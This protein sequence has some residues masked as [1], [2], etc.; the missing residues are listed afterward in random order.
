MKLTGRMENI[1]RHTLRSMFEGG[2]YDSVE[3]AFPLQHHR[4]WNIPHFEKMLED[5]AQLLHCLQ[6][7]S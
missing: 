1:F 7:I 4:D 5:N 6:P 2:V 3:V